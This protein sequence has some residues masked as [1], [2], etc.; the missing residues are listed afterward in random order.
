MDES[1]QGM[2]EKFRKETEILKEKLEMLEIKI[3]IK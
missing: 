3:L 1:V 2:D